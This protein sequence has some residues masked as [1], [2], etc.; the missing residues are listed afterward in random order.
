MFFIEEIFIRFFNRKT[1]SAF[2]PIHRDD[3]DR[4]DHAFLYY[5]RHSL[6]RHG[7][8]SEICTMPSALALSCTNAP[9]S[10]TLTTSPFNTSPTLNSRVI[11]ST[12]FLAISADWPL[13]EKY[14]EP[15]SSIVISA[16]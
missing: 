14:T 5:I 2:F 9:K 11:S 12:I 16:P 15:L 8:I 3:L 1:D 6:H 7:A 4:H 13:P 10:A